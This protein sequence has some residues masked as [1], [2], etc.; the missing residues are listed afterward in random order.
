MSRI[1]VVLLIVAALTLGTTA[2]LLAVDTEFLT[3][4]V[5]D[6]EGG[7]PD[8]GNTTITLY[9]CNASGGVT[10]DQIPMLFEEEN[11]GIS[12][13]LC[14]FEVHASATHWKCVIESSNGRLFETYE[15]YSQDA[16]EIGEDGWENW[17]QPD[18]W[19]IEG[20]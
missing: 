5:W 3:R 12:I 9:T 14:S 18:F 6:R 13:W 2:Q 16:I 1:S 10:Y 17:L 11:F 19:E 4:I 20:P 7:G 8:D 15:I